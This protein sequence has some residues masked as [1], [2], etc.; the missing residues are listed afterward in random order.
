[1][2][3]LIWIVLV[4]A[5]EPKLISEADRA[6]NKLEPACEEG[7]TGEEKPAEEDDEKGPEEFT[8]K[9]GTLYKISD[10]EWYLRAVDS[11]TKST[12]LLN[13]ND[14]NRV[15]FKEKELEAEKPAEPEE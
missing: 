6:P 10:S 13:L 7:K 1:M 3:I 5:E 12:Y 8:L 15:K 14:I 2:I 11:V 9:T 4:V